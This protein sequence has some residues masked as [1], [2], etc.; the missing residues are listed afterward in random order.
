VTRSWLL[1]EAHFRILRAAG[2]LRDNPARALVVDEREIQEARRLAESAAVFA[3]HAAE[4]VELD[5]AGRLPATLTTWRPELRLPP[6]EG[7][8]A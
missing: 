4:Q 2:K 6:R 1:Q 5:D 8:A 7:R 3:A